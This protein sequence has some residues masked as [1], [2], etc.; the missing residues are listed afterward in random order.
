MPREVSARLKEVVVDP[1]AVAPVQHQ[2]G[3]PR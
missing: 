3:A 1:K 2:V